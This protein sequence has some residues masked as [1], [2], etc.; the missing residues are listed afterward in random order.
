M[1]RAADLCDMH[2]V[3]VG[4]NGF[5]LAHTDAER[6]SGGSLEDCELHRWLS[7]ECDGPP[8]DPG[9]YVAFPHVVD[10]YSEVHG[11]DPWDLEPFEV[12]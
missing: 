4:P 11:S 3:D 10:A 1:Q 8:V 6:A 2:L 12:R 7:D 9:V 5:T